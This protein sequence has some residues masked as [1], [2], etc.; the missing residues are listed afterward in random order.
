MAHEAHQK[1]SDNPD[2]GIIL[3]NLHLQFDFVMKIRDSS[4]FFLAENQDFPGAFSTPN[5]VPNC[6]RSFAALAALTGPVMEKCGPEGL[7]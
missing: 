7:C 4:P 1:L 6:S 5:E 3:L 2:L